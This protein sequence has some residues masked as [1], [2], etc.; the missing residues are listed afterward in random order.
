MS[1]WTKGNEKTYF[2][3]SSLGATERAYTRLL[4]IGCTPQQARQDFTKCSKD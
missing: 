1:N 4:N 2:L 3:A